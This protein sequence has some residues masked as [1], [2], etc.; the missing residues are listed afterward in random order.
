VAQKRRGGETW[1][2]KRKGHKNKNIKV[3]KLM[4]GGKGKK[5]AY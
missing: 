5:F 3:A 4:V 2:K 1:K